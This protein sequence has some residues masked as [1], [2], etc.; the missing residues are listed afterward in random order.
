M[1]FHFFALAAY[2][3]GISGGDRIFIEFARRWSKKYPI[4]IFIWEE[5][6]GMCERQNLKDKNINFQLVRM[7][8]WQ[9]FGFAVNYLAR[10]IKGVNLGLTLK[11]E[12]NSKTVIYSAS[13]FWM[14]SLPC[15]ILKLRSPKI[16]WMAAWF[17]TAPNPLVGFREG[18]REE[19][20]NL[21][22]LIYYLIQFPIKPLIGKSADYILVNNEEEKK[23][24]PRLNKL[25]KVLVFLGAVNLSEIKKQKEKYKNLAKKYD[26]I[27][28]GRFHPQKGVIELI[29]IWKKVTKEFPK[30]KLGM[31]GDGSL[32]S[33]VKEKIKK[34]RLDQNIELFGWVFDGPQKYQIFAQSKV[35]VHPAFYDSGGMAAAEAMAFDL[36]AV[37]F[38]LPAFKSYYPEGMIKVPIGNLELFARE[39]VNL[40]EDKLKYKKLANEAKEMI[41]KNWDW[42]LRAEEILNQLITQ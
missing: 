28:Q 14:D 10:I 2:G 42:D 40:L 25:K 3:Q 12:N 33:D 21:S 35:V 32:M 7:M 4:D 17:Q 9:R 15:F 23:Q 36:P 18:K 34:E 16:T 19:G 37:G 11:L 26:G 20:Y 6:L 1:K 29:E 13:E 8:T 39:I 38:D 24:F 22:A 27:F 5:G 31:I 30:A 41:G